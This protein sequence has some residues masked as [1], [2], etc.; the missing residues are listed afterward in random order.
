VARLPEVYTGLDRERGLP[1]PWEKANSPQAWAAATPILF[2]QLLLG[3]V[4]DAPA[5]RCFVS[6]NLP[7]W[8]P[9]LELKGMELGSGTADIVVARA[10]DRTVVESFSSAA[11]IELVAGRPVAPLWGAPPKS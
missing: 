7:P 8:L 10:G 2:A 5:G 1:V 11:G 6:P 9:R 3:L 4:P